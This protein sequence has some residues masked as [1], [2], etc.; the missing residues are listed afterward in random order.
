MAY[1]IGLYAGIASVGW[2]ITHLDM[3]EQ[4]DGIIDLG[5]RIFDTAE[6]PK[7][8]A[9]LA[10]PRRE[11]RSARRRL[12][13]HR[14]RNERIRH[15]LTASGLVTPEELEALFSGNLE[16]IYALR[17]RSLE[18]AVTAGEF[19]R[20]LI[21]IAQRRGFRSN[22]KG[23]SGKEDGLLLK[24][25][26]EN[27]AEMEKNGYR[28]VAELLLRHERF[29]AH[30]RNKGGEYITTVSRDM[31]ADEVRSIFAAQR[32][33]GA[34][35]ATE[36]LEA[37]Y[38]AIL[39]SQRSFD[40]GPGE[41]TLPQYKGF[42][43]NIGNCALYGE[44][45]KRCPKACTSFEMFS[46]LDKINN[47]YLESPTDRRP[48]SPEEREKLVNLALKT[49]SPSYARI[50]K[51]LAIAPEES[52]NMVRPKKDQS[53]EDAEKAKFSY[54]RSYHEIRK[55]LDKAEKKA[56]EKLSR[57]TLDGIA[58]VLT[59]YKTGENIRAGLAA[60]GLPENYIDA[61][62]T[63][64]FSG[65]GHLSLRACKELEPHLAR[66]LRYAD[67][68]AAIGK[69]HR[70]HEKEEKSALISLKDVDYSSV[71]SPVVRRA[72]SQTLK[73]VNAII[74]SMG[75]SPTYVNI[76]LAREMSKTK[77]ERNKLK[78]ANQNNQKA[79]EKIKQKLAEDFHAFNPGG[80]DILKLKLW[81]EQGERCL[82]SL[83]HIDYSR[84]LEPG[85]VEID[86]IVPYSISFDNSFNNKALVLSEENRNKGN[87]LP[88]QYLS[89]ERR[90]KFIENV[91]LRVGSR[92]K[93]DNLLKEKISDE[94]D[95][96]T[97]NLQDTKTIAVFLRN[98]LDD[99][100]A[101]APSKRRKKRVTAVNGAVT[102]YLRKRWGIQKIREDGD[103]HHARDAVV[104][105]CTTDGMI[106]RVT[107]F[108]KYKE[109]EY[110]QTE[111]SSWA[112]N[113]ATGE[114]EGR[115]PLPWP[116]FR[117]ELTI[118][119]DNDPLHSLETL[120][121]IPL[122]RDG[123]IPIPCRGVFVSRMPNHK[124]TGA[125][126]KDTVKSPRLK[127]QGLLIQKHDLKEL[128]LKDGEIADYYNKESDLLLYNALL[129]RLKQFDGNAEQAFADPFHK[130]RSDGSPGPLVKKVKLVEKSTM[131]VP[132]HG[133]KGAAD[134][135]SMV[136]VDV[137][138]VE[139]EGYY[140]IP[141]YVADT[142]KPE[143]PNRAIVAHKSMEE[144]K[145]MQE[146]D[147][148]FS[149][150][151]NDLIKIEH[152]S[153]FTMTNINKDST[154]PPSIEMH[155][156]LFYYDGTDSASGSI[157]IIS[158]DN[159]YGFHGLGIKTLVSLEKYTV[160]VLG[161]YHKVEKEHRQSFQR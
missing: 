47:I 13:R 81:Q 125:A 122:Y 34:A 128:K 97:R 60:L 157:D 80:Q 106:Q 155:K 17:V 67:A 105:A 41:G 115:F 123:E 113:K 127:A 31:V 16:D 85:Y 103:L 120:R 1:G 48:L 78:K 64:S 8:G 107:R 112:V 114:V 110:V 116:D 139:G 138:F 37:A 57:E 83:R 55:A 11:A 12:R 74:R 89:G 90:E 7:T 126:H 151:K 22:R 66:G 76:E 99:E 95:F 134:N 82:Y 124:V 40:E 72:V 65:Y 132:V 30:K 3:D 35:F 159:T 130:P 108:A 143:L 56:M 119:T 27:R 24:A 45:E 18:E 148:I 61:L 38:L 58:L 51:E 2:A 144:W 101:F 140:L 19:A 156:G 14:H 70:G 160:D 33:K 145:P 109:C 59:N 154:L 36:E 6:E 91:T 149:L 92:V 100:L 73:V 111:D 104:I 150:Y 75:E 137:F 117:D 86:H 71:T 69:D 142:L 10:L 98:L 118:R 29:A 96:K 131:S 28:S 136:R 43:H 44:A 46:L 5:V 93:R 147:F 25:V 21:H 54:M 42:A 84:L 158:H 133:G 9:S 141:I 53:R 68:C 26:E 121:R 52:F 88:L 129:E 62:E 20:I 94:N 63:V 23:E 146:E 153:H 15:L 49:E 152:K 79:N 87:R 4:P 161:N 50:R 102:A 77:D 32:E 135:D 39:L